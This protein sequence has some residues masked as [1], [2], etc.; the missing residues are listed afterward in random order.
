MSYLPITEATL[1]QLMPSYARLNHDEKMRISEFSLVWQLFE[2]RL[3]D[4]SATIAKIRN[5]EWINGREA[6]IVKGANASVNH[7]RVRYVDG[8]Q[9]AERLNS[10]VGARGIKLREQITRGLSHEASAEE[11]VMAC[12]AVCMRLR[13]NLF[14]GVKASKGFVGQYD[15]FNYAIQFMNTCICQ[16]SAKKNG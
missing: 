7:F 12:G 14:H 15:N 16:I 8:K 3:F 9:A 4:C 10:L 6:L 5:S 2:S 13:N 11:E 1:K